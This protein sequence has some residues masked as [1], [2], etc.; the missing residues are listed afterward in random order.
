MLNS[1]P[2][3]VRLFLFIAVMMPSGVALAEGYVLSS[4][5]VGGYYHGVALRLMSFLPQ[6]KGFNR[7]E[8]ST[9]S[10]ENLERLADSENAVNVVLAQADSIRFYLDEHP[11]FE[12]RLVVMDDLGPECVLLITRAKG[13]IENASDLKTGKFGDL[14]VPSLGSGAAATLEYLS[15]MDPAYRKTPIVAREPM[16][17][18]LQMRM[19]GSDDVAAV[20]VLK[21]PHNLTPELETVLDNPTVFRIAPI[22]A[23]DVENGKLPDGSPIYT[24]EKVQT[25][26]G[27]DYSVQYETICTRALLV[28]SSSK[29]NDDQR[30]ELASILLKWGSLIAPGR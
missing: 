29:V 30:R 26:V 23:A 2:R 4:G 25:G 19:P 11:K 18:M 8:T 13:G 6:D 9:G 20:M 3:L 16:E 12:E 28:T 1:T 15:R 24:F 5:A 27:K 22:R 21:R 10:L 7:H 17:A 14:V